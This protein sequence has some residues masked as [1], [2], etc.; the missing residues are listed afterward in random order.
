MEADVRTF[1]IFLLG[2]AAPAA[3]LAQ[4][5]SCPSGTEDMLTYFVMGYPARV[6]NHMGPGN[7]NPDY[8]SINP[9]F[10]SNQYASSGY[11]LWTKDVAGYPWDVKAFNSSYIYDRTTELVWTD[12][13]TFKRFNTDVPIAKRCVRI[14]QS[15]PAIKV[16]SSNTLYSLYSQCNAYETDPLGYVVNSIS[17][18]STV[19]VGNVGPTQTR[20]FTYKYGCDSTYANCAYKEIYSLGQGIGLYD[21]KKYVRGKNSFKLAQESVI[22]QETLGQTTPSLPCAKSYQ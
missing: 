15:A 7:A 20:Y 4:T 22:N 13:T 18:P 10:N 1:F 8:S 14:G 11:F 17:A 2:I 3:M 5:L 21:W 9:D 12:P 19:N 16:P 6:D